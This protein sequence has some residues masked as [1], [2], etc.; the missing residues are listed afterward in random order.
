M[1][2]GRGDLLDWVLM[3]LGRPASDASY[4][5]KFE[6]LQNI[7]VEA[8]AAGRRVL[9]IFDE[10]QNM[11]VDTLE[12]L[13]MLSNINADKDE[14][15]QIILIGQ[16]QLRDLIARPELVQFAQRISAD[17]HLKPLDRDDVDRYIQYRLSKAGAQW[18]IFPS[19][20]CELIYQA[21][22]GVPRLINILSELCLVYGYSTESRVIDERILR[23]FL[24]DAQSRGLYQQ[25]HALDDGPKLV[26]NAK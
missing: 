23:E 24:N 26:K 9:L 17:F 21:T 19:R 25:F 13:R 10:A 5:H 4:I 7:I 16:P 1:Q 15:L 2:H 22:G 14:I 3:A 6:A 8:Y 18:R 12:E 20:T 11:S